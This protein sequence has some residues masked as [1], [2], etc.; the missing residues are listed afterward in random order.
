MYPARC[1]ARGNL[2]IG[3]YLCASLTILGGCWSD[4]AES[5]LA[6]LGEVDSGAESPPAPARTRRT[7]LGTIDTTP[8]SPELLAQL[9]S[10]EPIPPPIS[11]P[12]LVPPRVDLRTAYL[13]WARNSGTVLLV[14][15][16]LDLRPVALG[17]IARVEILRSSA[18]SVSRLEY[19]FPN[20]MS[21]EGGNARIGET[22]LIHVSPDRLSAPSA[23]DAPI[24]TTP[25]NRM[26]LPVSREIDG[27]YN[28]SFPW[29][30]SRSTPC[31]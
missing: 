2:A 19:R 14:V 21:C 25:A 28:V 15:R 1:A 9:R 23:V 17:S 26:A 27:S 20:G 30:T 12:M 31:S 22:L 29:A 16:V 7:P 8:P 18:G 5:A 11:L 10:D 4:D 6:E 13:E 3:S 24:L